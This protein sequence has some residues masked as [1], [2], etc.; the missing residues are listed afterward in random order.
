MAS[1]GEEKGREK[2][3]NSGEC[4]D[5][6]LAVVPLLASNGGDA[7]TLLQGEV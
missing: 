2:I 1:G 5:S 4:T 7:V 6:L 3:S